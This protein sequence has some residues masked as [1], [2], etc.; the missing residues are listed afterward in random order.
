MKNTN[1]L[2][3][4]F[5]AALL[6]T[7]AVW[8]FIGS[9]TTKTPTVDEVT[10]VPQSEFSPNP[11]VSDAV[12]ESQED[13]TNTD[14][15]DQ[16][17]PEDTTLT[18]DVA[19]SE[20]SV[21]NSGNVVIKTRLNS[22]SGGECTL[23]MT[24]DSEEVVKTAAVIFSPEFAACAGFEIDESELSAGDWQVKLSVVFNGTTYE[25]TPKTVTVQ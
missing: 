4:I 8:F 3:I 20:A 21:A 6:F 10:E 12:K 1:K 11:V 18:D 22:I 14:G 24:K 9:E 23:T 19:I 7:A 16:P 13:D 15:A 5:V 25:A 17:K 2:L